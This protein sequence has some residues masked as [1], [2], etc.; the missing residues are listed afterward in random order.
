MADFDPIKLEIIDENAKHLLDSAVPFRFGITARKVLESAF[1]LAQT[2]TLPD[3]IVFTLGFFGY[4]EA[5]ACPGY[6]GY[7]IETLCNRP[8][9]AQFYW[10]LSLNGVASMVGSDSACPSPGGT[11]T[12]RYKAVPVAPKAAK[13]QA[14]VMHSRRA[15]RRSE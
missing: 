9:N 1:L 7:E 12:W 6:L 13:T 8:S 5:A 10:E 14:A 2:P 15:G 3:P 4:S 11:V